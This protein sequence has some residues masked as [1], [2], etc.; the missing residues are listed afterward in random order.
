M[1]KRGWDTQRSREHHNGIQLSYSLNVLELAKL[2]RRGESGRRRGTQVVYYTR[3]PK[4]KKTSGNVMVFY[5]LVI[6]VHNLLVDPLTPSLLDTM[7]TS[8]SQWLYTSGDLGYIKSDSV[9]LLSIRSVVTLF[10]KFNYIYMA[11]V[12]GNVRDK[13]MGPTRTCLEQYITR[14]VEMEV[15]LGRRHMDQLS[16]YHNQSN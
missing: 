4:T 9:W 12:Y 15:G 14:R 11:C 3:F 8:L 16:N 1:N 2:P 13:H 10:Y 5:G 6:T 7:I